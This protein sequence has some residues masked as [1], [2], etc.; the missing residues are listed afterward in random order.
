MNH[1]IYFTPG[2]SQIYYTVPDHLKT[3]V[4][5]DVMCISHRS[6]AFQKIF[7][8]ARQAL[9]ELLGVPDG[10][11]IYFVS[12]AN[13]IWERTVQCLV[14]ESSH[15]FVN[16]SFAKK[17]YQFATDYKK[18]ASI[19]KVGDGE[20]FTDLSVPAS[21]ELIS[22]T[23]NETS[24]G[25]GFDMESL[26]SLR[27]NHPDKLIA[28]DGVSSFP[29]V[30]FDFTLADTAYFSV[31]KCFGLPAGLGVWIVNQKCYDKVEKLQKNGVV[32]GS[33]HDLLQLKEIGDK[34]QT[35][36]TPN[37]LGIYLLGKVC[38]DM[39]FRSTKQ[40]QNDTI[41][42]S[43]ILYQAIAQSQSITP[44]VAHKANQSKTVVV[45]S[46]D[47]GNSKVLDLMA[48]KGWIVGKGYGSYKENH[49]R[50]A[51]FPVH[52]KEHV[53]AMCDLISTL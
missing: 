29:A 41:Y 11:D 19:T 15:H 10:Y 49:I 30:N 22:V 43:T 6:G 9:R 8:E 20:P 38:R 13:E 40:I 18:N 17:F 14:E 50:I 52:S 4:S 25:F 31:Q 39:L 51:N 24:I 42:K 48:Q 47:G 26:R 1:K 12:S 37:V 45:A 21:A 27:K 35:P 36:E 7:A 23:L 53:E 34:N 33:Y 32:T 5:E 3:A 2:P 46:C 44:F 16:G 28:V